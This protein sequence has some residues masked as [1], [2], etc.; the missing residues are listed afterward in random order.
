[1][2]HITTLPLYH[3]HVTRY[4]LILFFQR[5]L[6]NGTSQLFQPT[7]SLATTTDLSAHPTTANGNS[8][9]TPQYELSANVP[10]HECPNHNN[11]AMAT[12]EP[13]DTSNR[14]CFILLSLNARSLKSKSS[15]FY[16]YVCDIKPDLVAVTETWFNDKDSAARIDCTPPNYCLSDCHRTDSRDGGTALL[17]K[18]DVPV[19]NVP[20]KFR[21][22]QSVFVDHGL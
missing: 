10:C 1:M 20:L 4:V 6:T 3:S 12:E 16:D 19:K 17:Y 9:T 15:V 18:D 13:L 5:L 14:K 7:I 21:N 8:N 22:G 11:Q 2:D